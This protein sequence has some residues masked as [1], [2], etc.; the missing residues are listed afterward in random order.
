MM[1]SSAIVNSETKTLPDQENHDE[2]EVLHKH[3]HIP[4]AAEISLHTWKKITLL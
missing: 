3:R 2:K 4:S 1:N